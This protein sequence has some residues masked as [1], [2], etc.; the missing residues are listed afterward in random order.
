MADTKPTFNSAAEV[1]AFVNKNGF[2]KVSVRWTDNPFGGKGRFWV[3][4]TDIPANTTLIHSSGSQVPTKT[5]GD[6]PDTVQRIAKLRELLAGT[7]A[8]VNH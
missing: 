5:F 3:K 1:R 4:L 6:N 8:S 7:N 2:P